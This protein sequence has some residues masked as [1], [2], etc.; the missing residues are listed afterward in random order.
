MEPGANGIRNSF[1]FKL[2]FIS[3]SYNLTAMKPTLV[4]LLGS[5]LVVFAGTDEQLNKRFTVSP[6]GG[7]L[8]VDV[9]FGSIDVKTNG[10]SEVTIDVV[11]NVALGSKAD[12]AEFFRD[13]PV[14][15]SQDGDT[16][17]VISRGKTMAN[18]WKHR[19]QRTTGK[20]TITVPAAF[21]AQLHTAG[22]GVDVDDLR[23][24]VNADTSGG[25]LRFARLHCDLNGHTSGGSIEV[26]D[27]DGTLRIRTSGGGIGVEGGSGTLDGATSG[28]SV[29]VKDFRGPA[30]V[31]TNGGGIT[32]ANVTGKVDGSTSG[33]SISARFS[34]P[35]SDEVK[36]QTSGGGVTLKVPES[37]AFD[38]DAAT[39][40]GTVHCDLPV[41]I[42]G[43]PQS[44]HIQGPVN[45]G[46]KRVLLRTSGGSIHISRS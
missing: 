11:R 39:S 42:T 4:V 45:G 44:T 34:T 1:C 41:T 6:G 25:G 17:T 2:S 46:G 36:L 19:N 7:K 21:A 40:A 30:R 29:M 14:S 32:V 23:G 31:Q 12:E 33:G 37:S 5:C 16:V 26:A 13:H 10:T 8:V 3:T 28:G 22:G 9:G 15:F 35:L 27:C 38:L 18:V 24:G 43:K 20:Y